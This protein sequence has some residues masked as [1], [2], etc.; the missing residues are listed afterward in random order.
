ML[1]PKVVNTSY[2]IFTYHFSIPFGISFWEPV[3]LVDSLIPYGAREKAQETRTV[4]S[5]PI[6]TAKQVDTTCLQM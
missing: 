1:L 6:T 3:L 4:K 5:H 2:L